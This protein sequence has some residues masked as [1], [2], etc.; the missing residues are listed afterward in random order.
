MSKYFPNRPAG[1]CQAFDVTA[2]TQAA[3]F[4]VT[5]GTTCADAAENLDGTA[6][7]LIVVAGSVATAGTIKIIIKFKKFL[8]GLLGLPGGKPLNALS[9]IK[10]VKV[11][12]AG[13]KALKLVKLLAFKKLFIVGKLWKGIKTLPIKLGVLGILTAKAAPALKV[14]KL[15]LFLKGSSGLGGPSVTVVNTIIKVLNIGN[16]DSLIKTVISAITK[17]LTGGLV[18]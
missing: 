18:G 2:D 11:I 6:T 17:V 12:K 9:L 7:T 14:A 15:L 3:A 10:T 1:Y 16:N 5:T 13:I 4:S 8:K